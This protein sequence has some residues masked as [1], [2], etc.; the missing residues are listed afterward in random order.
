MT[1]L[2]AVYAPRENPKIQILSLA[3]SDLRELDRRA[4]GN[5]STYSFALRT[6]S[7]LRSPSYL[8]GQGSRAERTHDM[9]I[10]IP[11]WAAG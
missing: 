9:S 8:T 7:H 10:D 5:E 3:V 6:R 2:L 4:G 11:C 1:H